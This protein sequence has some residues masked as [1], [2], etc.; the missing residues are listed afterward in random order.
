VH[1]RD[2]DWGWISDARTALQPGQTVRAA[3]TGIDEIRMRVNLSIRQLTPDPWLNITQRLTEGM[4]ING[5]ITG[6]TGFGVFIELLPGVQGLAHTSQIPLDQQPLRER[7]PI[8]SRVRV[9]ILHIDHERRRIALSL[10]AALQ[11]KA[12]HQ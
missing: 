3:V 10:S 6:V 8:G 4:H 5:T 12:A 9:T 2:I 11:Q 1:V 7:F